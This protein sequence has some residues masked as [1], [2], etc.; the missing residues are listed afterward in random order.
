ME[1][2]YQDIVLPL[3]TLEDAI[4]LAGS[5]FEIW[6]ILVYP[7]RIYDHGSASRQGQFR[8]PRKQ[9]SAHSGQPTLLRRA[10]GGE[11]F[12][13]LVPGPQDFGDLA[14]FGEWG[15]WK[16]KVS[17]FLQR[18]LPERASL[19]NDVDALL[20]VGRLESFGHESVQ[21]APIGG[22]AR[23]SL[24]EVRLRKGV[25][26]DAQLPD[27]ATQREHDVARTHSDAT[28]VDDDANTVVV[29]T[30]SERDPRVQL[31]IIG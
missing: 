24:R 26:N 14:L 31:N 28:D 30:V 9:G 6:P 25:W 16:L 8:C 29:A 22:N 10:E 23:S 27:V 13:R 3:H 4:T 7:S 17:E 15:E 21:G 2:V 5:L 18:N 20:K 1:R 19:G 12:E 11:L